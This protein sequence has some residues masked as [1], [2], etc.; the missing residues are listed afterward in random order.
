MKEE[1]QEHFKMAFRLIKNPILEIQL[2]WNHRV[3]F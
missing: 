1:I 3:K 2:D